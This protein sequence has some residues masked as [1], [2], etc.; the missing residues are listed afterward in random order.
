MGVKKQG[1]LFESQHNV[2]FVRLC[3]GEAL[4]LLV[5]KSTVYAQSAT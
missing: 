2:K 5:A 3:L 1:H 4:L